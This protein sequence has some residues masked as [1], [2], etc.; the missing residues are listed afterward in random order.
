MKMQVAHAIL[1]STPPAGG[2]STDDGVNANCLAANVS[3]LSVD[4]AG[5]G[6]AAGA[7]SRDT[8]AAVVRPR[9]ATAAVGREL[10]QPPNSPAPPAAG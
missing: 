8:V 7:A 9:D 6:A 5:A 1:V 4:A 10:L 3:V 2:C